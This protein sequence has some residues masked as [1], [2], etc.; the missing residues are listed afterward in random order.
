MVG[1]ARLGSAW[2]GSFVEGRGRER[3]GQNVFLLLSPLLPPV[4]VAFPST[5]LPPS[6]SPSPP[7]D[8]AASCQKKKKKKKRSCAIQTSPFLR[9][10]LRP[11]VLGIWGNKEKQVAQVA[12]DGGGGGQKWKSR[13]RTAEQEQFL[14]RRGRLPEGARSPLLATSSSRPQKSMV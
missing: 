1:S 5:P 2:L 13:Q 8:V 10:R 3:G 6:P 11:F 9:L 14:P 4:S 7:L 12:V